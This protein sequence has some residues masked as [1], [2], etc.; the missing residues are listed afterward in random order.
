[1][2]ALVVEDDQVHR[3]FLE[4]MLE[5]FG[6]IHVAEN[7]REALDSFIQA[8]VDNEPFN[9]VCLDIAMPEMDGLETLKQIRKVETQKKDQRVKV[10]MTT[11]HDEGGNVAEAFLS[12]CD[13]YLLKPVDRSLLLRNLQDFGLV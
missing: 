13:A 5:P 3:L 4:K 9:L 10:I 8:M 1:M 7:G 11:G 6:E 12:Q 2:K